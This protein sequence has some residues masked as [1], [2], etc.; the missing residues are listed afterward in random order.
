MD[1]EGIRSEGRVDSPDSENGSVTGP[2]ND[3]KENPN[4]MKR[5]KLVG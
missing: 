1:F 2:F 4:S 3:C 5:G